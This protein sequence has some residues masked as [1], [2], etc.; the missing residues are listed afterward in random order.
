MSNGNTKHTVFVLAIGGEPL[1]PCTPCRARKLMRGGVAKPTWSKFGTFGLQMLVE[2]RRETPQT[3][4]GVDNGTKFE[5]YAVVCD[6]ENNLAVKLDLPNKKNIVRK[7]DERRRLRR[8][9]RRR[10]CRRRKARFSN[11]KHD[12]FI[13]PS[14]AVVVNSRLRVLRELFRIYPI[15]TVA[16]EDV[17][18]NHAKH[19]WGANFSTVEIGKR[20][21]RD[22]F[23]E[24]GADL[25][26]F[27]GWE[28][29]A[30]REG[31]GY[32][33]GSDKSADR[34]EAHCTDALALAC[35]V[36]P[37]LRVEP[38]SFI[39]VDDTYRPMRRRLHDTQ[40]ARDGTRDK[41]SRG[42][43]FGLRKGLLIGT[44]TGRIGR[45]CG[46]LNGA[47]RYHDE[48]GKRRQSK[49]LDWASSQF[50]T[51]RMPNSPPC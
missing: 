8:A 28:T 12:G 45:L 7:L 37:G 11:R 33:K 30:L 26:E 35:E 38:G 22:F 27:R 48:E 2:T 13:A 5:G 39:V 46:E 42:T 20:R 10:K 14:Q 29:K 44:S 4:V 32:H 9:R 25:F 6:K 47:Y 19:R 23:A 18:F 17:R 40:P 24:Q 51:R 49:N 16:F 41:Y 15:D 43:V 1:T 34:F 3:T 31:Y 36:G 21:L 50:I